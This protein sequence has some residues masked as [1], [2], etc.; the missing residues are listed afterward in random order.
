MTSDKER[1]E[2]FH[3]FRAMLRG[4]GSERMA[5]TIFDRR[6]HALSTL[7]FLHVDRWTNG[8]NGNDECNVKI[9]DCALAA[10]F[11]RAYGYSTLAESLEAA[12]V[13]EKMV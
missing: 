9:T 3:A 5:V 6:D 13:A 12:A 10:S 4:Y 11:L 7:P 1:Q 2:I 8:H